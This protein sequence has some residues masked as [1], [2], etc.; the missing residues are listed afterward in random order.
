MGFGGGVRFEKRLG[1]GGLSLEGGLLTTANQR[2]ALG[3]SSVF[4][5]LYRIDADVRWRHYFGGYGEDGPSFW[6][7]GGVQEYTLYFQPQSQS[8]LYS[9]IYNS[10][11]LGLGGDL[12]LSGGT[13]RLFAEARFYLP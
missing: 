5:L 12:A 1:D 11:T 9:Q 4:S 6:A 7:L 10:G 2:V 13:L 3:N 8:Y